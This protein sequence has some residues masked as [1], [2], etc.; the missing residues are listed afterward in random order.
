MQYVNVLLDHP[1]P[2]INT[3]WQAD[4]FKPALEFLQLNSGQSASADE[5]PVFKFNTKGGATHLPCRCSSMATGV[6]NCR[7]LT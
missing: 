7:W 2:D 4:A 3:I 5:T 1:T 6:L